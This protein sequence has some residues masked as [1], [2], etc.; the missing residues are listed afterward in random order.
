MDEASNNLRAPEIA[1]T[2]NETSLDRNQQKIERLDARSFRKTG[3]T[4]QFA[5]RVSEEFDFKLRSIAQRN[6]KLLVEI[7]EEALQEYEKK[8]DIS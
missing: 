7:L 4:I 3:R 6:N 1:P 2:N 5:T 8:I